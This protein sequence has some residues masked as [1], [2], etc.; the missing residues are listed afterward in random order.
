[1]GDTSVG[2]FNFRGDQ[3]PTNGEVL[4]YMLSRKGKGN[5]QTMIREMASKIR[6]IW[7]A[8]D[9]CPLSV[10]N[11]MN[12]YQKLMKERKVYL[13]PLYALAYPKKQSDY[14]PSDFTKKTRLPSGGREKSQRQTKS[15]Y[16][17]PNSNPN[18]NCAHDPDPKDSVEQPPEKSICETEPLGSHVND[19]PPKRVRMSERYVDTPEQK[20]MKDIGSQLFDIHSSD[21]VDRARKE[22][23]YFDEEFLADQRGERVLYIEKAKVTPEF[24]ECQ[25]RRELRLLRQKQ[26]YQS[27]IGN[28]TFTP[29][30]DE[31]S[32]DECDIECDTEVR[33]DE[34]DFISAV[35]TRS[36]KA[37]EIASCLEGCA[38]QNVGIQVDPVD[39]FPQVS[40]RMSPTKRS[41]TSRQL[42]PKLLAAGSLLM[43]VVGL[44]TRQALQSI[45][46]VANV[47]F[48][49]SYIL[50]PSMEKDYQ[51]RMKN[52][53]KL[54]KMNVA[55]STSADIGNDIEAT[56][57]AV[58]D[59]I[60]A[61]T[62][63]ENVSDPLDESAILPEFDDDGDTLDLIDVEERSI[64]TEGAQ[65]TLSRMLCTPT[66]L[67]TAHHLVSTL[68]EQQQ[69]LEMIENQHV[70]L[71]PDGTARQGGWGKMAGAVMK[72]GDKYRSLKL[73]TLGSENH[74]SWVGTLVHMLERL[75]LASGRDVSEIWKS[76]MIMVSDMCRVNMNLAID[77]AKTLGC[78]WVPGQAY[79]NLHPRLM[80]SRMVVEVWMKHQSLI[81]HDKLFPSLEYCN[82]DA[83]ND[84]LIKQVL[85]ALMNFVSQRYAERSW[86]KFHEFTEWLR[87]KGLRNET[88][89]LREIRFG[90]LEAKALTGAYH[91]DHIDQFLQVHSEVRNKLS[92]FLRSVLPL[93]ELI[94]F[95]L[96]GAALIGIHIGEPYVNLLMVKKAKMSELIKIF[97]KLHEELQDPPHAFTQLG[98]P[99]IPCLANSWLDPFDKSDPPYPKTQ[100][101]FL[102]NFLQR[103]DTKCLELYCREISKEI[104]IGFKRQKGDI[105]GF[106][107]GSQ[108]QLN[109]LN[110]VAEEN[111]DKIETTSI[112]VEQYFGE[113]DYKTKISGGCQAKGK[114][115]DDL[116]IKHTEDLIIKHF[117]EHGYSLKPFKVVAKELDELQLKFDKKQADLMA[118]GLRDDEV[119]VLSKE[120]QVQRVVRQ[121]KESHGGPIHSVK[122][123]EELIK[124]KPTE[125]ALAS[126]LNYEIRYRKFTCLLKVATNNELFKQQGIDNKQ[127]IVH[128]KQLL[129][130]DTKPKCHASMSDIE[131][132]Y[133]Q[134]VND[135]RG[136]P[137][138]SVEGGSDEA[139]SLSGSWPLQ[140]EEQIV[141]LSDTGF[142]VATVD[143]CYESSV[144]VRCLRTEPLRGYPEK[145]VWV[146]DPLASLV[147]VPKE[148]VLMVRPL[149][150]MKGSSR[151]NLKFILANLELIQKLC[152]VQSNDSFEEL[153]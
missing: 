98:C 59:V 100:L 150:E 91:L 23:E 107:D 53:R 145:S 58:K 130:N 4:R 12:K 137:L 101:D 92:C 42:N 111:L 127:R 32:E 43:G 19:N 69:A 106:G 149:L 76:I 93:K 142:L 135:D 148:S 118:Q 66:T 120:S 25:K 36:A 89:P 105:F 144:D 85:D 22:N 152:S 122:E 140:A 79:C 55:A 119:L 3:Y 123:L 44:S 63:E 110:Q 9:G 90:E 61:E 80:M 40:T 112:A 147:S 114:I 139:N 151:R 47:L 128:L 33:M 39:F 1:M 21:E 125:K 75:S 10:K 134:P 14:E 28:L 67:R 56:R 68:G 34:S 94:Y 15:L 16:R 24:L 52:R 132:I 131:A 136:C 2:V 70:N 109:I 138:P 146:G 7:R 27:A 77:V 121:C 71:I 57:K 35:R 54:A 87:R 97:P 133:E 124:K 153:Y 81:G 143:R 31:N 74:A 8:G 73:Q 5:Q 113:V 72:V 86:N 116:L 13:R 83:S 38:K 82:L 45:K 141:V 95:Y 117:D 50:P 46:T 126:A 30:N 104:A 78:S 26:N 51:K 64:S 84:S 65:N 49:Q 17:A 108:P 115:C 37:G 102:A 96:V 99:A 11:I 48:G 60:C 41:G 103:T 6:A 62:S 20:W 18:P 29:D 88:G 129:N